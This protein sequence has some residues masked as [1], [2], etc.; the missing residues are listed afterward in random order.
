MGS[1]KICRKLGG[2]FNSKD[3]TCKIGKFTMSRADFLFNF[4]PD[5]QE[6]IIMTPQEFL[7]V[8]PPER[9]TSPEQRANLKERIKQGKEID[10]A[11]L[12]VDVDTCQ[13]LSHEGRNRAIVSKELGIKKYPVIIFNKEFD[14]DAPNMFGNK[15]IH[16][17]TTRKNT[18][19]RF[20]PQ[21]Y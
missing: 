18:C 16:F 13:V 1:L 17:P 19:K 4:K 2:E 11:F 6:H 15:G 21:K 10:P 12:D 9:L 7:D 20:I 14:K 3:G 8:V 5:T